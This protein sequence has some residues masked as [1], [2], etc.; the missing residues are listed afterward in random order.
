MGMATITDFQGSV[1]SPGV[2]PITRILDTMMQSKILI[3]RDLARQRNE[4]QG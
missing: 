3:T 4:H 1:V 2:S